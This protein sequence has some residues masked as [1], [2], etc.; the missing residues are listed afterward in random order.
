MRK[1]IL[2][3]ALTLVTVIAG[4]VCGFQQRLSAAAEAQKLPHVLVLA[5]GGTIAGKASGISAVG[6]TAGEVTGKDLIAAAP[7]IEKFAT[8]S[9]D[10]ISNIGSQDMN[11]EVWLKLYSRIKKAF[12]SNEAD[13]IVITHGTDTLEETAFFLE[14]VLPTD[15]PV[16]LVGSMRPSTAVSADGPAN[17]LEA[18]KV[19]V[20]PDS[21]GRGVLVVLNDLIHETRDVTKGNT[22]ELQAFKSPNAGPIGYVDLESVRFLHPPE[23]YPRPRFNAPAK[24]PMPRV[25]IIYSHSNMTAD[26]INASVKDGAKGI[27]LAGVGDGNTSKPALAALAVAAKSGVLVVRSSRV[28]SGFTI[29]NAEINDDKMG[30]ASSLDLNPQKARILLQLLISNGVT[31]I[32]KVQ[33][34]IA[35]R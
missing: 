4:F 31:D 22:T 14:Q 34:E 7:G 18:V 15:K 30:F 21:Q 28:G 11:D 6:Y 3:V 20:D 29:R 10:Q 26:L 12:E 8:L 2:L 19:A 24:S 5:T 16:V 27:I 1:R 17:L 9:T 35:R 32:D 13:G 23:I 25:D 33:S